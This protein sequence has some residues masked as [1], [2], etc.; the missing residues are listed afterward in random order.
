MGE[1]KRRDTDIDWTLTTWEGS[2]REQLRRWSRLSLGQILEA[3]EE[4][5]ALADAFA[6][7]DLVP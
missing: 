3:Q 2:Q 4:M 5:Q 1:P 6:A 7:D